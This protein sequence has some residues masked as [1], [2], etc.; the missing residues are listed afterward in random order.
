VG[1]FASFREE[2]KR[3]DKFFQKLST[4]MERTQADS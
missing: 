2:W 3:E 4:V 1:A